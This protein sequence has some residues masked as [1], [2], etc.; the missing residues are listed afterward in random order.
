MSL[1]GSC[2]RLKILKTCLCNMLQ[3]TVYMLGQGVDACD[4]HCFMCFAAILWPFVEN[5]KLLSGYCVDEGCND[6]WKSRYDMN[7]ICHTD[8]CHNIVGM[9]AIPPP[10]QKTCKKIK[11]KWL[12]KKPHNII[13]LYITA[14][15][16]KKSLCRLVSQFVI[17]K[18]LPVL[19]NCHSLTLKVIF[20]PHIYIISYWK[21]KQI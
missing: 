14:T 4:P 10:P 16:K 19:N 18:R 13:F 8:N 6:L 21:C 11:W 2:G 12:G 9:S 20:S 3:M 1:V 7:T 15:R 17:S 5:P